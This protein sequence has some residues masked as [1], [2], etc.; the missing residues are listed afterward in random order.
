M[1]G[2]ERVIGPFFD[3]MV[4]GTGSKDQTFLVVGRRYGQLL[5]DIDLSSGSGMVLVTV[6]FG[7]IRCVAWSLHFPS[8]T[9]QLLSS[10]AITGTPLVAGVEFFFDIPGFSI[11]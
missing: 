11:I 6:V 10:N 8:Q 4:G 1:D 9:E 3:M 5:D 2:L 7:G